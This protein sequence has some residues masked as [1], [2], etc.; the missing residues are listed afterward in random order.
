MVMGQG[1]VGII[2]QG[3][4][5]RF[6]CASNVILPQ[7]HL[8]LVNKGIHIVR[9][10]FQDLAIPLGRFIEAVLQNEDLN[11]VFL[12]LDVFGVILVNGG[13][14]GNGFVQI[15]RPEIEVSQ[16]AVTLRNVGKFLLG[17]LKKLF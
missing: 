12:G 16:H 11:K 5:K 14:F 4:L 8:T 1:V 9:I 2:A 3:G 17:L 10:R 15:I 6:D 7:L 13:V